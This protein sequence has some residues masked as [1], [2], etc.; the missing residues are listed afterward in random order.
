MAYK[1]NLRKASF[2]GVPFLVST[3]DTGGGRRF[4]IHR[5]P[6][7]DKPF[8]EDMGR[9]EREYAVEGFVLGDDAIQKRNAVIDALEKEGTGILIHPTFGTQVVGIT[10]YSARD[11]LKEGRIAYFSFT[12]I[13]GG[14][15]TYPSNEIDHSNVIST[16]SDTAISDNFKPAFINNYSVSG[17]NFLKDSAVSTV[18]SA[19]TM[20]QD[21]SKAIPPQFTSDSINAFSDVVELALDTVEDLIAIPSDIAD[22]IINTI[23]EISNLIPISDTATSATNNLAAVNTALELTRFGES[24]DTNINPEPSSFGGTLTAVSEITITRIQERKNQES[25]VRLVRQTAVVEAMRAAIDVEFNS[26]Q[27]AAETRDLITEK[28]DEILEDIGNSDIGDDDSFEAL[29]DLRGKT[30][31]GLIAVGADLSKIE[32]YAVPATI[33]S[34]LELAYDKY[35]DSDREQE[36]INRNIEII[37]PGFL[38][39]N[40]ELEVLNA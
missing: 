37:H 1:D 30:V 6:K 22:S 26:Y 12:F 33:I 39:G 24:S 40:I 17:T 15:N 16:S 27:Q 21:I 20:L 34:S 36:I 25:I 7:R 35:E 2:R 3:G 28:T 13:E 19:F 38:P 32:T 9:K 31:T 23:A 14:E 29:D 18:R 4:V 5:Y 10:D 8:L 11:V